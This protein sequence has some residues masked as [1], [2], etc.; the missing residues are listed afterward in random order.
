MRKTATWKH[1]S[2][3][4]TTD[5]SVRCFMATVL[6]TN[7]FFHIRWHYKIYLGDYFSLITTVPCTVI[8]NIKQIFIFNVRNRLKSVIC[9][10]FY[11][12]VDFGIRFELLHCVLY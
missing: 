5:N 3:D 11:V 7:E 10:S 2:E 1:I 12:D 9:V 4:T 6:N 8:Y